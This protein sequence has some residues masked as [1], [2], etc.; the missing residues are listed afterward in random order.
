MLI[1]KATRSDSPALLD[2]W[3]DSVRASHAFL[4]ESDIQRLLPIVRDQVLPAL[5]LWILCNDSVPIGFMG[6]GENAI[7]A[8]FIA[9]EYFRVGGGTRLVSF[10]K[11]HL[12]RPLVVDV[13]EQNQSA[14]KFYEAMGFEVIGRSPVDNDGRPFPLLHMRER[15]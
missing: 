5:D 8:L 1:R 14:V 4:A 15:A 10:A 9:P 3:L 6:V 2:I 7:E 12:K 11:Q 13:N